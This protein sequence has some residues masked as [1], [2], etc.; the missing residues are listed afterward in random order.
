VADGAIV[1]SATAHIIRSDPAHDHRTWTEASADGWLGNHDPGG[2]TLYG[3]DI[4]VA[5][6]WRGRGI[7]RLLYAARFALVRQH[8]LRRFLAGSRL[9]GLHH[10]PGLDAEAYAAAVV[11]GTLVDPVVTPQ[12]R[13]GL[14]PLRVVHGYLADTEARDCALL[15]EWRNPELP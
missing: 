9:A 1:A 4:A 5:P 13:A 3:V 14:T 12:L 10:H 8:R 2:D 6:P 15:M 7:A 11:A